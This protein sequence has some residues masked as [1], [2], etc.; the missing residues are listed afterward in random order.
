MLL[1]TI[2]KSKKEEGMK[3]IFVMILALCL[4]VPAIS[5]AGSA[6]SRWDLTIGGTVKFQAGWADSKTGGSTTHSSGASTPRDD[7]SGFD[8]VANDY[9]HQFWGA[10]ETN[11]SFFVRGPEVWGAKT[12][13]LVITE[14]SG[15][16]GST[17][18][19]AAD[20]LIAQMTLDWAN[21]S[22]LIGDAGGPFGMLPTFATSPSFSSNG[23]GGKG[24][25]PVLPQITLTQRFT[26][27][28]SAKFGIMSPVNV[29]RSQNNFPAGTI[30]DN[31]RAKTP[32]V[33][34]GITYSS[35]AC[36][37]V[38]PWTLTVGASGLYARTKFTNEAAG[39]T[40]DKDRTAWLADFKVL[41][42]VIPQRN[43]G[44]KTNA[45]Y[46]DGDIFTAQGAN[47]WIAGWGNPSNGPI[48]GAFNRGTAANPEWSYGSITG[49]IL[50]GAYY[51]S[52]EFHIE[53]FYWRTKTDVS[54]RIE[55]L[56]PNA[57]EWGRQIILSFMYDP[58]PALRFGFSYENTK[59]KYY[60]NPT[61]AQTKS[62]GQQSVYQLSAY[63]YF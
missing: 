13:A 57:A 46:F 29:Y 41:V 26:K 31:W 16:W 50:H 45:L 15:A 59:T 23:F 10:G 58:S 61:P 47:N 60:G 2:L 30:N 52:D 49:Y 11:L 21:T 39:S 8:T 34:A 43:D 53:A 18:Y 32:G 40:N 54:R 33:M 35:D 37:R 6:T 25:A 12:S 36:G 19:G 27:Q 48:T 7:A 4:A 56:N 9:G 51:V 22:L 17:T 55:L 38:G 28:W 20:L 1:S 14:F 3:K 5:Y 62:S 42:P 63:Y 44:N 24:P